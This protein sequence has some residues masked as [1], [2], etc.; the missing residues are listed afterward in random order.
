MEKKNERRATPL[1]PPQVGAPDPERRNSPVLTDPEQSFELLREQI[2]ET[3][4]SCY[5]N[6]VNYPD[7]AEVASGSTI[8]R[9][10]RGIWVDVG[11]RVP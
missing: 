5:F 7:G 8:L 11:S 1:H 3:T 10:D 9:C 4:P 2:D 6:D